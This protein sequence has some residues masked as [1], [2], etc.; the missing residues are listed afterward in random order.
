MADLI[1]LKT[2]ENQYIRELGKISEI[3]IKLE[4]PYSATDLLLFSGLSIGTY[5]V[6]RGGRTYHYIKLMG[7]RTG[8]L[9]D[10]EET[11]LVRRPTDDR[12][13]ERRLRKETVH[14]KNLKL[15]PQNKELVEELHYYWQRAKALLKWLHLVRGSGEI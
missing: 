3:L 10:R 15:T 1:T 11:W 4:L 12:E 13:R 6:R 2:V 9:S 8:D 14:L 5:K 7:V